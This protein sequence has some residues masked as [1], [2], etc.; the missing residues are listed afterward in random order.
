MHFADIILMDYW[1]V[2][3]VFFN[4]IL[5]TWLCLW[6]KGFATLRIGSDLEMF[7]DKNCRG[8]AN[9]DVR[10]HHSNA[11]QKFNLT[12]H[13]S[14]EGTLRGIYEWEIV[15]EISSQ[16]HS[17]TSLNRICVHDLSHVY[18]KERPKPMAHEIQWE[19]VRHHVWSA[20]WTSAI[21]SRI[22]VLS[23]ATPKREVASLKWH[24][25]QSSDAF[26]WGNH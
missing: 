1:P 7:S 15:N 17:E 22:F 16:R 12:H 18:P 2:R 3:G 11:W 26:K 10:A 13:W 25:K 20:L 9:G 19:H 24:Y 21:V 5:N 8:F 14:G 23:T 4:S 6:R